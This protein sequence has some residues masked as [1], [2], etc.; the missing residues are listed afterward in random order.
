MKVK[1]CILNHHNQS[2]QAQSW[3]AR[4]YG[5]NIKAGNQLLPGLSAGLNKRH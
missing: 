2:M 1:E 3:H 5:N 4:N